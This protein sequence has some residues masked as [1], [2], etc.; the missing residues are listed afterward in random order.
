[1]NREVNAARLDGRP[2]GR[3]AAL[4]WMAVGMGVAAGSAW[5]QSPTARPAHARPFV[6]EYYYKVKWGFAREFRALFRKNHYPLLLEQKR[7]GRIVDIKVE[8]PFYHATEDARW[9][10]RVTIAWKDATVAHDDF[11]GAEIRRRL[12]P[13]EALF[14]SEEQ[15]RFELLIA[16]WDVVLEP[17]NLD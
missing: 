2:G 13:D 4:R 8:Q 11:D 12:F 7:M 6:V 16:H 9:D 3:R 10:Y 17:V 14:R 1:M 15:R 5:A